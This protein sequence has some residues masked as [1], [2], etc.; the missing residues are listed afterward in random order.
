MSCV[1]QGRKIRDFFVIVV[2]DDKLA[3][4]K[5]FARG[6]G[7]KG[8]R[9]EAWDRETMFSQLAERS[10]QNVDSGVRNNISDRHS[11]QLIWNSFQNLCVFCWEKVSGEWLISHG[12]HCQFRTREYSMEV[13]WMKTILFSHC[14]VFC[15]SEWISCELYGS[16]GSFIL[17]EQVCD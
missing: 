1:L 4:P 7:V 5:I 8:D 12:T 17:G 16:H 2:D 14:H 3:P 6:G 9:S 13:T 11:D 15:S 10:S